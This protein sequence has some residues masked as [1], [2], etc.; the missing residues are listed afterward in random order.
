[1]KKKQTYLLLELLIAFSLLSLFIGPLLGAPFQAISKEQEDL[2]RC[3]ETLFAQ[4]LLVN[5]EEDLRRHNLFFTQ[6]G[7]YQNSTPLSWRGTSYT[8]KRAAT[9]DSLEEGISTVI[10]SIEL[11]SSKKKPISLKQTLCVKI[12]AN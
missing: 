3:F 1:M 8:L 5:F 9:L 4:K 11:F 10:L 6:N 12:C 7:T 2:N